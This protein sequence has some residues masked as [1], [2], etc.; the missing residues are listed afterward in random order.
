MHECTP[1]NV[2]LLVLQII[3]KSYFRGR[4]IFSCPGVGNLTLAS[5]KLLNQKGSRGGVMDLAL[6]V[7]K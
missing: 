1:I 4:N 5:L 6:L 7:H 2:K 3:R